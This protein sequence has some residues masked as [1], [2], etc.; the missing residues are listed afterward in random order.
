MIK[1]VGLLGV[2]S[3]SKCNILTFLDFV[4]SFVYTKYTKCR[5][6]SRNPAKAGFR[7]STRMILIFVLPDQK[8]CQVLYKYLFLIF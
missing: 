8:V 6:A 7:F 2:D 4:R 5:K 3:V 1:S